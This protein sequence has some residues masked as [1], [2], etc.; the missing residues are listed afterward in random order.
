MNVWRLITHHAK[1]V[2]ALSY[3][4]QHQRVCIGWSAVG[5]IHEHK[6]QSA[7]EIGK[8]ISAEY[9]ELSNAAMG[10]PTL[11][12]FYHEVK[13]GDLIIL[14]HNNYNHAVARVAG[15]YDWDENELDNSGEL[16]GYPHMRRVTF[17]EGNP[18][19]LWS[20]YSQI[21]DGQNQRWTLTRLT[22]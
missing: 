4:K 16:G 20:E 1:P 13:I 12:N 14:R 7:Q 18:D 22:K 9:P 6:Y 11:W 2:Q 21:A 5:N 17:T 19:E 15:N 3:Y 10:G 8:R